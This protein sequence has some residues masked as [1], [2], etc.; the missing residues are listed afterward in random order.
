MFQFNEDHLRITKPISINGLAP[1]IV[2]GKVIT[3]VIHLPLHAEK[4]LNEQNKRLPD[5]LKMKIEKIPGYKPQPVVAAPDPAIAEMAKRIAELEAQNKQLSEKPAVETIVD[6]SPL[7][8]TVD[9]SESVQEKVEP[10]K[11]KNEKVPA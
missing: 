7:N 4:G 5:G 11:L 8:L 6:E 9:M 2:D 1:K 10:K 3:R